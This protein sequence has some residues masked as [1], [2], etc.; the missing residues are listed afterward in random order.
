MT[1]SLPPCQLNDLSTKQILTSY[2]S[3]PP[4]HLTQQVQVIDAG[5]P[6]LS[7]LRRDVASSMS[8]VTYLDDY[9]SLYVRPYKRLFLPA[10]VAVAGKIKP[11][12][13]SN[14]TAAMS[15]A[16]DW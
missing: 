6:I 9:G 3:S 8:G 10:D 13:P 2:S 11:L 4:P 14:T 12:N 15:N 5:R 7:P 1:H 16:S